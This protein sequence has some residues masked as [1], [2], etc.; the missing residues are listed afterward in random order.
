MV[1]A[2]SFTGIFA[3]AALGA[4]N[5]CFTLNDPLLKRL[6]L[7]SLQLNYIL[8][9]DSCQLDIRS[10]KIF[11]KTFIFCR[12]IIE[13]DEIYKQVFGLTFYLPNSSLNELDRSVK[14]EDLIYNLR[15]VG[16]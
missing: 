16:R 13:E 14:R 6:D 4:V 11:E 2:L 7:F 15:I 12:R 9:S 10:N 1:L 8:L 3:A 5:A